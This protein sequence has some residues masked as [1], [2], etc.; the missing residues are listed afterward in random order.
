MTKGSRLATATLIALAAL[1]ALAPYAK[2]A[3]CGN[4]PGGYE[5]WKQEFARE[6][7]G[8]GI[9]ATAVA[10]LMQTH[11][12][13]ATIAADR[14]QHSFGLSLDQF[15]AKRGASTIVSRGRSVKQSQEAL[16]ASIQQR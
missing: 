15:L 7:G 11:Y 13:G 5:T 16:F 4:G 2:A 1:T 9:G 10:A 8:K 3:Q 12:A 14:S 6:A